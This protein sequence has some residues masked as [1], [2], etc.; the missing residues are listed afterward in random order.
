MATITIPRGR[1]HFASQL[2]SILSGKAGDT[3]GLRKEFIGAFLYELMSLI[4]DAFARKSD[5][6]VD[7]LGHSFRPL[8][9]S[10]V[11]HKSTPSFRRKH[12]ASLPYQIMRASN[13]LINSYSAGSLMGSDYVPARKQVV[14]VKQNL[15][16]IYS[17]LPYAEYQAA[18]RPFWPEDITPWINQ[19]LA[20]GAQAVTKRLEVLQ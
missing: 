8:K 20:A 4:G 9:D 12:P 13:D 6:G 1:E 18:K 19:A 14:R 2:P 16:K 15:V 10:T 5:G 3:H 7:S 17:K 11:R